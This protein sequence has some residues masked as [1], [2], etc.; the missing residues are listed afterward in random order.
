M[1]IKRITEIAD[2][3]GIDY[4]NGFWIFTENQLIDFVAD[5]EDEK[6]INE[7]AMEF[8]ILGCS[9]EVV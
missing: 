1:N 7:N 6:I 5:V 2:K 4:S 9:N 3:N 8:G